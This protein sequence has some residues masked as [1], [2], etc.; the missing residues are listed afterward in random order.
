[1]PLRILKSIRFD[2]AFPVTAALLAL[3]C[4][5]AGMS[6]IPTSDFRNFRYSGVFRASDF[7]LP[8]NAKKAGSF[9]KFQRDIEQLAFFPHELLPV[10]DT[11]GGEAKRVEGDA[12]KFPKILRCRSI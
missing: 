1:M 11:G 3:I 4:W 6:G 5:V 7:R 8:R 10:A 9:R 12:K 2:K